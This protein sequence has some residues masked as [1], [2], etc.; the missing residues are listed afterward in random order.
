MADGKSILVDTS[1]C[2]ACRGCQVACK[3][4]NGLP[5]T[6]TKQLG[7]YQNPRDLSADTWRLVRFAE[8]RKEDGKPYWYFFSD[9]CRHCIDPPCMDAIGGYVEGGVIKDEATGAILYTAKAKKAPF[10]EVRNACP[11]D[12]PRQNAKTKTFAKCTMCADRLANDMAPAC[13]KS[14][15]TGALA[16]GE[17]KE[18]LDMAAKRVDELKKTH[19][20]AMA[21]NPND[22]RVIYIVT[23]DPVKY[24]KYAAS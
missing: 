18:I 7:T 22:V 17:R 21:L 10:E 23:D 20:K 19:P 1:R 3:Q 6:K 13:V 11:F 8:G 15:P 24:H 14:C 12:I 2:T 16:F 4:W 5:G 9:Q